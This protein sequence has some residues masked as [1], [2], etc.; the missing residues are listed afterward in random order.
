MDGRDLILATIGLLQG[1]W[2]YIVND[3]RVRLGNL[4]RLHMQGKGSCV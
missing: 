2:L 3:L 1:L 4:E